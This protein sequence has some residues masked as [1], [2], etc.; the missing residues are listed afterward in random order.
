MCGLDSEKNCIHGSDSPQSAQREMSFFF[1]EMSSGELLFSFQ[2]M[3]QVILIHVQNLL[4]PM[5]YKI[6]NHSD[7]CVYK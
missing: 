2:F 4:T 5:I 6:D 3:L 7:T 1:K